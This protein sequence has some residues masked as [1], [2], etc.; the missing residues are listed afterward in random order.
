MLETQLVAQRRSCESE[1]TEDVEALIGKVNEKIAKNKLF[2]IEQDF[3]VRWNLNFSV[4]T[5]KP[6]VFGLAKTAYI[7]KDGIKPINNYTIEATKKFYRIGTV[8]VDIN[9]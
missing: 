6:D 5:F 8:E 3:K 7:D 9:N 1:N 4:N 2:Y